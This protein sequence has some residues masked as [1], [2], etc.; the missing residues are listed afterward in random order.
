MV[1]NLDKCIGCHTCSITCKNVWTN[2]EGAEYMYFNNVETKPG[3]GYPKNWEDQ[4]K[5]KGGWKLGKDGKLSL[6]TGSKPERLLKLFYHPDQPEMDDYYEPWTYDYET[7]IHSKRRNH[8]PIA[9][10]RSLITGERMEIKWGPN[11]EDCVAACPSGAIYK[12]EEDGV[13]LVSQDGCRGWRHCVPACPYKK[14]YFNWKTNKAEKCIFC[15]PR[16]ENGLPTIC[17]DTCVGRLRY[18]GVLLY[19]MD[20]VVAA[21]N[22]PEVIEAARREGISEAWIK[23]AQE[24]PV[25]KIVKEWQLGLPLHPEFRTLPMVWYVPPLS[26]ITRRMEANCYLPEADE[27]R[28]P[29][30]Y[31]AEILA[32]GN[33]SVMT[34]TLQRLLDMR[35]VMRAKT[36]GDNLPARLE[37]APEVYEKMF[38][39][40]GIAKY[41][42][43]FNI[44][45]GI[46]GKSHAEMRKEQGGGLYTCPGGGC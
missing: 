22:D 45:A 11:W 10:P 38:R 24:S 20:K 16:L 42:D 27:M 19:D 33:T 8:Q 28:I 29:I 18:M 3:I 34:R 7:L 26:P 43:R 13:V 31:L 14:V 6:R 15:F 4:E 41:K 12:R 23:A 39:L 44:P 46:Q 25:Y 1:M 5:W 32:A 37:F 30:A 21:P 35:A 17:A 36:T 2:R 40:L 9:R